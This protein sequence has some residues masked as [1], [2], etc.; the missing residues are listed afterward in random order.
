MNYDYPQTRLSKTLLTG[1]FAGIIATLVNLVF[2]Y[3]YRDFVKFYPSEFINVSS[4]IFATM[5]LFTVA[6]II[7]FLLSKFIRHG[8]IVYIVIFCALTVF[9]FIT[10][11]HVHRS[12]NPLISQ[13]FKGLLLGTI[14][15]TG[16]LAAF[17]IPYLNNH[18]T[19]YND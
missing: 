7:Y 16:L 5:L 6:G 11:M 14:A 2:D 1:V 17:L 3:F 8:N 12:S 10:G 4:I 9:C 15:L 19:L 18:D 13:E